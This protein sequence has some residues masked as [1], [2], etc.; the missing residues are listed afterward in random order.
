[1]GAMA[2]AF[3]GLGAKGP[4]GG[5]NKAIGTVGG[6]IGM[7]GMSSQGVPGFKAKKPSLGQQVGQLGVL[8]QAVQGQMQPP[9][10]AGAAMGGTMGTQMQAGKLT[11][12]VAMS[13][14]QQPSGMFPPAQQGQGDQ[15]QQ[16]PW[17]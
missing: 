16:N 2:N 7:P 3:H 4:L 1:M 17:G 9:L 14:V 6:K 5:M 13:G 15:N 10:T 11:P 12:Q 8:G